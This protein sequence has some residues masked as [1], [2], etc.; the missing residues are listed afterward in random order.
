M[1]AGEQPPK[2]CAHVPAELFS[3]GLTV[4]EP[5]K[6]P[7]THRRNAIAKARSQSFGAHPGHATAVITHGVRDAALV[8]PLMSVPVADGKG[9]ATTSPPPAARQPSRG[10]RR[11]A[12]DRRFY[13]SHG[14]RGLCPTR[15][16]RT[17][18]VDSTGA[19]GLLGDRA[20]SGRRSAR[21]ATRC[22]RNRLGARRRGPSGCRHWSDRRAERFACLCAGGRRRA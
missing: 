18:P 7:E 19:A 3:H 8:I 15:R 2:S 20:S 5:P 1:T 12:R 9:A 13:G 10:S 17:E 14:G 16:V 22:S 6:R 21:G 11:Q 4:A